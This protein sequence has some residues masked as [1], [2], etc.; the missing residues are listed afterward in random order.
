MNLL[1][2]RG[3]SGI[4]GR[5]ASR[6]ASDARTNAGVAIEHRDRFWIYRRAA[7]LVFSEDRD[8]GRW[9]SGRRQIGNGVGRGIPKN[10]V[11]RYC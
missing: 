7:R 9:I 6:A 11:L 3:S 1:A 2:L 5:N 8:C 4:C 10:C